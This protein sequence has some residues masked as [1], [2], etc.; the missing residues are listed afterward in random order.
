MKTQLSVFVLI[1]LFFLSAFTFKSNDDKQPKTITRTVKLVNGNPVERTIVLLDGNTSREDVISTC[2]FLSHENV[3]LTFD[4][5]IIGKSFL[6]LVGKTRIRTAEGRIKLP[7]GSSQ[8][9]KAGG[10][11]SFRFIK[12]QYENNLAAKSFGIEMIE[13]VD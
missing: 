11:T 2:S 9:F 13:I 10:A 4:K 8:T 12:I 7:D 6:G 3:Q 5:L 1:S